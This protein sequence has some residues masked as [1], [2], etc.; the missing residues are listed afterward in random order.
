MFLPD[1]R[2]PTTLNLI[3]RAVSATNSRQKR[4]YTAAMQDDNHARPAKVVL[5]VKTEALRSFVTRLI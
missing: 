4:S 1:D 3:Q 2:V 5:P